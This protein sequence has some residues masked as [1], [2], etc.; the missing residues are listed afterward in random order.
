MRADLEHLLATPQ[1]S[2][3]HIPQTPSPRPRPA[4]RLEQTLHSLQSQ[5]ATPDPPTRLAAL[6]SLF[7]LYTQLDRREDATKVFREAIALHIKMQTPR[8]LN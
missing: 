5:L 3:T 8:S 6:R 7:G 1:T 2:A 4:L